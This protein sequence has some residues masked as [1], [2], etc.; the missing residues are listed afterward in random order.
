MS[1]S[2]SGDLI[3]RAVVV[4]FAGLRIDIINS[5]VPVLPALAA[6]SRHSPAHAGINRDGKQFECPSHIAESPH[7]MLV[8]RHTYVTGFPK[9]EMLL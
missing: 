1:F 3:P 5:C 8:L 7:D 2:I 4:F 9:M 6:P